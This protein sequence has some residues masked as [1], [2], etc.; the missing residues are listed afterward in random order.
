MVMRV[1]GLASGMDIEAMVNKLM[2][3]ERIPLEKMRQDQTKLEWKRDAFRDINRE[4]LKLDELMLDMK[5][6]RTYQSKSVTSSQDN[7]ITA[8]ARAN[9]T[10]G[11]YLINV[12]QLATARSEERRVGRECRSRGGREQW[13]N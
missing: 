3:A 12:T 4:L 8:T 7:A 10:P 2:E 13:E 9:S 11:S 6:S 5:L 1:G